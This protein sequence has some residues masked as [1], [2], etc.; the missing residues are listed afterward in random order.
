M[1]HQF[2]VWSLL[3]RVD[4]LWNIICCPLP[5]V[6]NLFAIVFAYCRMPIVPCLESRV[7]PQTC[8]RFL[9]FGV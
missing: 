2:G 7:R 4:T 3:S 1:S 5:V 6:Y 8:E 9:W